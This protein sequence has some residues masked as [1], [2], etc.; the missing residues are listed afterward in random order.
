MKY[1]SLPEALLMALALSGST[2]A[3]SQTKD[4][5]YFYNKAKIV[6]KLLEISLG[7]AEID[8]NGIGIVNIKNTNIESIHATSRFFRVETIHGREL[9]GYLRRSTTPGMVVVK[10]LADS[11]VVRVEDITKL[12]YYGKTFRSRL[13]GNMSAGYSYTKSS[14]IGRLNFD[15]IAKYNTRNSTSAADGDLIVTSESAAIDV[16]RAN[17]T[18]SHLQAISPVWRAAVA[19]KYQRNLELGLNRRWQEAVGVAREFLITNHQL[20]ITTTGIAIN[21][22][23]NSDDVE[24]GSV[25]ALLSVKYDFF[26][27]V[28]PNL[29]LS[30][31]ESGFLGLTETD[32]FRFDGEINIDYE[33][34]TDFYLSLQFYHNFDSRSPAT[35]QPNIDYGF[36]AGLRYK[37]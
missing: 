20:G 10:I 15:G 28:R 26:S 31:V 13:T 12:L 7:R 17:F 21:Q 5:L 30:F 2:A 29:T 6:G 1:R 23:R 11:A 35:G 9:Q 18:V 37:F 32:R 19:L 3:Y 22:E 27:F 25:E 24:H 36:V 33:L 34:V 4:T 16:E 14:D 8:A